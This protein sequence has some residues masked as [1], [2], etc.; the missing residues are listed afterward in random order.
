V[1]WHRSV[2]A[3]ALLGTLWG[4]SFVAIEAGLPYFP[5]LLF[6]AL[7]YDVAGVAVFGYAVLT[8]DYWRPHSGRDWLVAAIA[9][10]FMIG[11]HHALLYLG[12]QH[13]SGTVAA[14]VISLGPVLTAG[15]AAAVLD[16]PL[17]VPRVAGLSLGLVGVVAIVGPTDL[18]TV[19]PSVVGVGLVFGAAA[20]FALGAVLTRP[21]RTEMPVQSMQAWAMLLGAGLL[22]AVGLATGEQ[23]GA[24]RWTAPALLSLA[25]LGVV[26]GAVA[27]LLYFRLLDRHGPAEVNLVGYLEPVA[28]ALLS[29]ALFGRVVDL[30]TVAGFAAILLGFLLVERRAVRRALSSADEA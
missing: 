4:S 21:F 11:G 1:S 3:F 22:H 27:F 30:Q 23:F 7:R 20:A 26:T 24:V 10:A 17:T 6:A 25:H 5:P 15:F 12:Q 8:T 28:A 14:V 9:G 16:D 29:W 19:T 2:L 13:V 18:G